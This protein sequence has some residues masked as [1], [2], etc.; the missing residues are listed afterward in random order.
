MRLTLFADIAIF[1][2]TA[3]GLL[4]KCNWYK[5]YTYPNISSTLVLAF[6]NIEKPLFLIRIVAFLF[7]FEFYFLLN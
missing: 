1:S 2:Q 4:Y 3:F 7:Y 6:D 5:F